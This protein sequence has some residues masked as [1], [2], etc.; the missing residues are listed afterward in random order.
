M[1]LYHISVKKQKQKTSALFSLYRPPFGFIE[2]QI[3]LQRNKP[4]FRDKGN[5]VRCIKYHGN[6]AGFLSNSITRTNGRA[7]KLVPRSSH[8]LWGEES[9]RI[10]PLDFLASV[11]SSQALRE[12][13]IV[14]SE[15]KVAHAQDENVFR[16]E[17]KCRKMLKN[18]FFSRRLVFAPHAESK[19]VQHAMYFPSR[20]KNEPRNRGKRG[21]HVRRETSSCLIS[22]VLS[23]P[24]NEVECDAVCERQAW[25]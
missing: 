5:T 11:F 7:W 16:A 17:R 15:R 25:I 4:M 1:T 6:C 10:W 2:K 12:V 9:S 20:S 21:K 23:L 24:E 22:R 3:Y 13:H 14:G 19:H 18:V 8:S